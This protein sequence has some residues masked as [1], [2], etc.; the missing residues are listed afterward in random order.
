[1][2]LKDHTG[3]QRATV[4]E[5]GICAAYKR[6]RIGFEIKVALGFQVSRR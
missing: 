5:R 6:E 2:R 3:G 4:V 1:M